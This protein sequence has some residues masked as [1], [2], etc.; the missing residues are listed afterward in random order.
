MYDPLTHAQEERLQRLEVDVKEVVTSTAVLG[1]KMDHM[2]E[3]LE[4]G[5]CAI[6]DRLDRGADQFSQHEKTFVEQ[7][8]DINRLQA[9]EDLRKA[10]WT[11]VKRI[12]LPLGLVSAGVI[13]SKLGNVAWIWLETLFR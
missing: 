3:K 2:A 5:F 6:N 7:R 4:Q 11:T 13:A 1:T 9:R 8:Q 12:F 10:R